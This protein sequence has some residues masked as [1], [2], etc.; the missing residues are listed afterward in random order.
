M[1]AP[2]AMEQWMVVCQLRAGPDSDFSTQSVS[3]TGT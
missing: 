1:T 2:T 3:Q